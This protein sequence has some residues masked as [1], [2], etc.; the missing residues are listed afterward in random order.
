[1]SFEVPL[2]IRTALPL[3]SK[4]AYKPKF[5]LHAKI[6]RLISTCIL[7][8][9][10][11][12]SS[13]C[14]RTDFLYSVSGW[15][16]LGKVRDYFELTEKQEAFL[17]EKIDAIFEWHKKQELPKTVS[18]LK[19]FNNRF[20]DGLTEQDLN[21]IGADY[22]EL[23]DALMK[24]VLPE[25]TLFLESVNSDQIRELPSKLD[26]R[27]EFLEKKLKLTDAEWEAKDADWLIETLDDW[28]DGLSEEQITKIKSWIK[29]DRN[30]VK[31]RLEQRR[32][33]HKW[34]VEELKA[35]KT[36]KELEAAFSPWVIDPE[37][38][39]SPAF[40]AQMDKKKIEW[41]KLMLKID[42]LLT[43]NQRDYAIEKIGNYISSF[44]KLFE[45]K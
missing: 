25:W 5:F 6:T 9:V 24:K 31:V 29:P 32:S 17:T 19:E 42:S 35:N 7:L 1:L 41:A 33:F 26:K 11:S 38:V 3:V 43:K 45:L 40:K 23:W 16:I 15:A 30:F 37:S 22:D 20:Q 10:F 21:V 13:G 18:F 27:N 39:W 44:E 36:A 12:I 2:K 34:F 28:V 14:S 4:L 8:I